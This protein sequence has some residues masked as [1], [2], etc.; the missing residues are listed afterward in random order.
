MTIRHGREHVHVTYQMD[1][2]REA[3]TIVTPDERDALHQA[4]RLTR[5][6]GDSRLLAGMDR[7]SNRFSLDLKRP[8]T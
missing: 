4:G 7:W 8:R 2:G 3:Q 6:H 5:D 1:D